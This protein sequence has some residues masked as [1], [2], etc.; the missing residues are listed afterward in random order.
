MK[1][2]VAVLLSAIIL[3]SAA[4]CSAGNG[5]ENSAEGSSPASESREESK[6]SLVLID[7]SSEEESKPVDIQKEFEEILEKHKFAGVAYAEKNG[8]AVALAAKGKS[9]SGADFTVDTVMPVGSISKQFCTAAILLLQEKGKL[10]IDDRLE[11]YYPE[12]TAAKDVR[13]KDMLDMRSGIPDINLELGSIDSTEEENIAALSKEIFSKPLDFE[14]DTAFGYSNFNYILLAE[15]VEKTSGKKYI[16]YLRSNFFEPLGM[17][18]TGSIDEMKAGQSWANGVSYTNIELRP[19]LTKGC[20]ELLSTGADISLWLYGLSSGKV[21]SSE[22]YE[23]MTTDYSEGEGYGYGI[24]PQFFGGVGHT[25]GIGDYYSADYLKA[26]EGLTIFFSSN[27]LKSPGYI[28]FIM[29]DLTKLLR[30]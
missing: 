14:T 13:L 16:D 3:C 27:S 21:I 4:A 11:K 1:K 26:D 22:S 23:A 29:T 12:Y 25:G 5:K 18:N 10:S 24:R 2:A 28:T 19:G 9:E 6:T 7:E 17:K 8:K 20:G 30:E 15:I